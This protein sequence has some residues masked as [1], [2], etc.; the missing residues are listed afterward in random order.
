VSILHNDDLPPGA[1][2]GFAYDW[3][4]QNQKQRIEGKKKAVKLK[5]KINK[6]TKKNKVLKRK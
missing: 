3:T 1:E 6:L 2:P 4:R 5:K